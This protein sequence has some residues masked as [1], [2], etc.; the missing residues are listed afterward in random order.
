MIRVKLN[1][2]AVS[3]LLARKNTTQNALARQLGISSGGLSLLISGQRCPLPETRK[4]ILRR[5]R[6]L[7]FDDL[8]I[9]EEQADSDP[10]R[11]R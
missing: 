2:A 6:E 4:K 11:R 7:K 1:G 9:I 8:F 5:L 10:V 3:R